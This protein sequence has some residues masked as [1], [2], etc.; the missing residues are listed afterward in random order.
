MKIRIKTLQKKRK[1]FR[2]KV[3]YLDT[4]LPLQKQI[5]K[6]KAIIK[7]TSEAP[8]DGFKR[9]VLNEV[10]Y[11]LIS[12]KTIGSGTYGCMFFSEDFQE[13][14]FGYF[15]AFH[16]S[17]YS[18]PRTYKTLRGVVNYLPKF[19]NRTVDSFWKL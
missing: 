14:H 15:D 18:T 17:S 19:I 10:P 6:L 16:P 7:D 9:L 5:Q 1:K 2:V 4:T 11:E 8:D 12:G 3:N 13:V